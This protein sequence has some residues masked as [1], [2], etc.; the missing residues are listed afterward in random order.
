MN[1]R[2][3]TQ[4]FVLCSTSMSVWFPPDVE[5]GFIPTTAILQAVVEEVAG[6]HSQVRC[7]VELSGPKL[8]RGGM[9]DHGRRVTVRGDDSLVGLF[10]VEQRR[11]VLATAEREVKALADSLPRLSGVLFPDAQP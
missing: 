4:S 8:K 6:V 10:S 11:W 5:N 2:E 9:P 1:S 3:G 7:V